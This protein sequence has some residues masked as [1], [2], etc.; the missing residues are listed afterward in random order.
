MM[1]FGWIIWI[2]C[3]FMNQIVLFNFLIAI[4]SKSYDDVMTK[5][6]M[7]LYKARIDHINESALMHSFIHKYLIGN[8]ET[9]LIFTLHSICEIKNSNPDKEPTML[10]H[11]KET[12][13][14]LKTLINKNLEVIKGVKGEIIEEIKDKQN[15]QVKE[16]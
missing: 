10:S 4:I 3:V 1:Y 9:A 8:E 5:A 13:L 6:D 2:F 12:E 15:S 16:I 7:I 11:V 14:N